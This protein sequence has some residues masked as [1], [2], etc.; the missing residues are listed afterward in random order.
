MKSDNVTYKR[1][2]VQKSKL[3]A[4]DKWSEYLSTIGVLPE[5]D[6]LED[7]NYVFLDEH[8]ALALKLI[9]QEEFDAMHEHNSRLSLSGLK[10]YRWKELINTESEIGTWDLTFRSKEDIEIA[11]FDENRKIVSL[12]LNE[13]EFVDLVDLIKR[14]G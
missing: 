8:I 5:W 4:M 11:K 12:I 6:Q 14:I 13:E 2:C 7:H 1:I 3:V 10:K 9:D